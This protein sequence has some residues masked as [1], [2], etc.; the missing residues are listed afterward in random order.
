MALWKKIC[1]KKKH[2]VQRKTKFDFICLFILC[3]DVSACPCASLNLSKEKAHGSMSTHSLLEPAAMKVQGVNI[4]PNRDHSL[5]PYFYS[6][7]IQVPSQQN[8]LNP[9]TEQEVHTHTCSAALYLLTHAFFQQLEA[10][11]P[12][13]R[14]SECLKFLSFLFC[15][16]EKQLNICCVYDMWQFTALQVC[17]PGDLSWQIV[18]LI[19][20]S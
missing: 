10:I 18:I 11:C 5:L 6:G 4:G 16:H 17:V 7:N 19:T 14:R 15:S 2:K 8:S 20:R 9:N 12:P 3:T 13:L 1:I